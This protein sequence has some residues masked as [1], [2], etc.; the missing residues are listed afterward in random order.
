[1]ERN[2][3]SCEF[4]AVCEL[5]MIDDPAS[6]NHPCA[7]NS[8]LPT[9]PTNDAANDLLDGCDRSDVRLTKVDGLLNIDHWKPAEPQYCRE[10]AAHYQIGKRSVQKWF[11]ELQKIVPWLPEV[12][13]KVDDR[14]TPLAIELLGYR[15]FAGSTKQWAIVL[16]EQY[17]DCAASDVLPTSPATDQLPSTDDIT[18]VEWQDIPT[19]PPPA[20]D[21]NH[22]MI[23]IDTSY[24][25]DLETQLANL[26]S[27][28]QSERET[29]D[30]RQSVVTNLVAHT[31]QFNQAIAITDE[32]L[33]R[34][35]RLEGVNLGV[36]CEQEKQEAYRATRYAVATGRIQV[37]PKSATGKPAG[38]STAAGV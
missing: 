7:Q 38:G 5:P 14:Y 22:S 29:L 20:P 1:M 19:T 28:E 9:K 21:A 32:L 18:D 8:D 4:H 36:K 17:G 16:A 24:L 37:A 27:L 13:L 23:V 33:L 35:S 12:E 3:E 11:A 25:A 6:F 10:I 26:Q 30:Y 2:L 15:Y 31:D 34:Q